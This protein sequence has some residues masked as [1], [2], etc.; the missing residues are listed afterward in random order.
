LRSVKAEPPPPPTTAELEEAEALLRQSR[1]ARSRGH[2]QQANELLSQAAATAP[3][4]V[5]VQEALGDQYFESH[6]YRRAA[7][8]YVL[9]LAIEANNPRLERKHG[10]AVFF[11]TGA[12]GGFE[13]RAAMES[14][15]NP[16]AIVVLSVMLPGVG[17]LVAGRVALGVAM[18]IGFV[19]GWIV[20]LAT[21]GAMRSL[22]ASL[23]LR[24]QEADL[25]GGSGTAAIVGLLIAS[26]CWLWSVF[27][28]LGRA[29]E[30]RMLR[31]ERPKPPVEK[32][33]E[34]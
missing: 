23:G 15:A 22:L 29:S 6:Q 9:A 21:P 5:A 2:T 16:K 10:D 27:E 19:G 32:P 30:V 1:L 33:F 25:A 31:K 34:L 18:L 24:S 4:S 17:Q 3:G 26:A 14:T 11:A 13:S 28:A 20:A 12:A 8:C 7:E